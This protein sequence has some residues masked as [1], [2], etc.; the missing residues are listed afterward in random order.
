[1]ARTWKHFIPIKTVNGEQSCS[2][3]PGKC[4][5]V[6][7]FKCDCG[8]VGENVFVRVMCYRVQCT[9]TVRKST[10]YDGKSIEIGV[11]N[12]I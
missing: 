7:E 5:E 3:P 6:V 12:G 10:K 4:G 8:K 1:M 9:P 11:E 2:H